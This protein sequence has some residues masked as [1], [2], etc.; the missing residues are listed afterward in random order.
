MPSMRP[1]LL[2][3]LLTFTLPMLVL[4]TACGRAG[5]LEAVD[6]DAP[7]PRTYPAPREPVTEESPAQ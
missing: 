2:L 6:S 4:P 3:L 1:I 7:Y 5:P